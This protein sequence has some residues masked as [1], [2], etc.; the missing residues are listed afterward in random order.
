MVSL[1]Q[2]DE[3]KYS[4]ISGVSR[5]GWSLLLK[6]KYQQRSGGGGGGG[7]ERKTETHRQTYRLTE[8]GKQGEAI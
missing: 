7:G 5:S 4:L 1:S 8:K 2:I 3:L 6:V